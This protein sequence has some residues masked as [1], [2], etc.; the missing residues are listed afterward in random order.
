MKILKAAN[1]SWAHKFACRECKSKLEVEAADLYVYNNA[2]F[3][4][5][6]SWEPEIAYTCPVCSS[7]NTV[8]EK[9]PSGLRYKLIDDAQSKR[10]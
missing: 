5:G 7:R 6:E 2:V 9:V 3:Y 8:T 4:A 1:T 10:K